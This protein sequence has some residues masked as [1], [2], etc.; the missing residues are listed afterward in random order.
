MDKSRHGGDTSRHG[1][2][3]GLGARTQSHNQILDQ[4]HLLEILAPNYI[5]S[6]TTSDRAAHLQVYNRLMATSSIFEMSTSAMPD[7][8]R[9]TLHLAFRDRPGSLSAIAACLGEHGINIVHLSAFCTTTSIAIDT[10]E[11]NTFTPA[12]AESIKS[13]IQEL[14]AKA[15]PEAATAP[16]GAKRYEQGVKDSDSTSPAV[17]DDEKLGSFSP[18]KAWLAGENELVSV[19]PLDYVNATTPEERASH[20]EMYAAHHLHR[21]PWLAVDDHIGPERPWHQR[22]ACRRLLDGS[23]RGRRHVPPFRP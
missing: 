6:T 17:A 16:L 15:P 7:T 23:R 18:A 4:E 20:Q 21:L 19:L 2:R 14:N 13:R 10:V 9:V 8:E 5:A 1:G 3:A 11:V 12:A 22:E